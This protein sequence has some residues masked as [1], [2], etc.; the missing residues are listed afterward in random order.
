MTLIINLTLFAISCTALL[1][2][3]SFF[4]KSISKIAAFLKLSEFVVS[5]IIVGMATSLP[6]LFVG[7]SS[8]LTKQTSISLG[9]VIGSNIANLTI[10]LGIPL[11]I[12]KKINITRKTIKKDSL[13]MFLISLIPLILMGLGGTLSRLDGVILIAI[14]L[15]YCIMLVKQTRDFSKEVENHI[16]RVE[17]IATTFLFIISGIFLY[18]SAQF[19]VLYAKNV[20]MD[21]SLPS[22]FIG[23]FIIALGTSLPEL[24]VGF[25][26]VVKKHQQIVLGNIMGSVVA[27][28]TLV[29]GVT[30]IITPITSNLLIFFTSIGFMIIASFLF[31]MFVQSGD[32]IGWKE[33]LVMVYTYIIFIIVESF[34]SKIGF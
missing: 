16:G 22:I 26:S 30:A 23:L 3:G 19:T 2:S 17:I 15:G 14:F 18:F 6:E 13:Y 8:A 24:V 25:Q 10:I 20:S 5:F 32:K 28:S 27:N 11:L 33:A 31:M 7:I 1:I 4:I 34:I 21:L 12:A 29:L 9:N